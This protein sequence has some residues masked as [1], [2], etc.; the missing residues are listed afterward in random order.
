MTNHVLRPERANLHGDFDRDRPPVLTVES[1]ERVTFITWDVAWGMENHNAEG[2]HRAKV[3]PRAPG[4]C[5]TGPVAV[6]GAR[7]G[8]V[9]AITLEEVRPGPW[10]WTMAGG[11]GFFNEDLNRRL[12]VFDD[13]AVLR[14]TLK[15]GWAESHLGHRL[16]T[17]PFPGMLGM[18]ADLPGSQS[19]WA[20]RRTGGNLDCRHLQ[21]GNVLYLPVE[22]AGGLLSCGDGHARQ[23]DGESGGTAIECPMEAVTVKLD[24]VDLPV[25]Q[26]TIQTPRGWVVLGL[27]DNLQEATDQAL[28]GIL[29]W[30]APRLGLT[31]TQTLA[32][33]GVVCHLQITQLVNGVV[34]VQAAWEEEDA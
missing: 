3:E 4:P 11:G 32:L 23:G 5:L 24:V 28:D 29:T 21:A 2:G 17:Y 7:P 10:G 16:R 22:V 15:N 6:R 19:G 12:G 9:L 18:P 34:G 13:R 30:M 20:P 14:W 25:G 31:R 33:A 1:G 26:P 27:G 8:D